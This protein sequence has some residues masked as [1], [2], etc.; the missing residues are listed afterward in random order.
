MK[1]FMALA[2][3][4]PELVSLLDGTA[5]AGLV[6]DALTGSL[7][8]IP[9]SP[10]QRQSEARSAEIQQLVDNNPYKAGNLTAALRL[11]QLD[12][13]TAE[14]LRR[15]AGVQTPDEK[16]AAE[17]AAKERSDAA[18]AQNMEAGRLQ[19]L[20]KAQAAAAQ[21]TTRLRY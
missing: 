12:A 10:E 17:K 3:A 9:K 13:K 1:E 11:E 16:A 21:A 8:P 6:A 19:Q 5:P 14:R 2:K 4:D 18:L 15:E 20:A 7:P